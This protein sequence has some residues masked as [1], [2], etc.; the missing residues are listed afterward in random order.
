MLGK[1]RS[2]GRW[3]TLLRGVVYAVLWGAVVRG[4]YDV[5]GS[6]LLSSSFWSSWHWSWRS[7]FPAGTSVVQTS[8]TTWMLWSA[9]ATLHLPGVQPRSVCHRSLTPDVLTSF[10]TRTS[11][12]SC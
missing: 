5:Q 7:C 9:A 11:I 12:S 8:T 2:D 3:L 10:W 1:R 4:Y 6:P